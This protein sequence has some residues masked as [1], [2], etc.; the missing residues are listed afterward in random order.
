ML[1]DP[2]TLIIIV[3]V[4]LLIGVLLGVYMSHPRCYH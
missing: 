1:I 3:L 4:A 2:Q